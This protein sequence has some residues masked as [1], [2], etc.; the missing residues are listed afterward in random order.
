MDKNFLKKAII[1]P[2]VITVVLAIAVFAVL[3]ANV[4]F[5]IPVN[6]G[7]KF[8]Y[9]ENP[10][11]SVE[12]EKKDGEADL[13][14]LKKNECI[15]TVKTDVSFPVRYNSDYVN[16]SSS[17]SFVPQSAPFGETGFTY[18]KASNVNAKKVK[19]SKTIT[20]ESIFGKHTYRYDKEQSFKNEYRV[21]TYAP[22][23]GS[24][25]IIYYQNANGVGFSSDYKALIF[26]EVKS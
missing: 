11:S 9:H 10:V 5:Y 19:A 3:K 4:D 13:A 12:F 26:K 17:L 14:V 25:V 15:G 22:D 23:A 21:L 18:L 6:N 8:A 24:A 1:L 2:S 16:L 20:I 7:T